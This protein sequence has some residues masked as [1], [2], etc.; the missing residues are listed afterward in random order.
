MNDLLFSRPDRFPRPDWTAIEERISQQG[1]DPGKAWESVA[2]QWMDAFANALGPDYKVHHSRDILLVT[3]APEP[4]VREILSFI[5]DCDKRILAELPFVDPSE[6]L[7]FLPIIV[8]GDEL[9]FYHYLGTLRDD[10]DDSA[11]AGGVFINEGYG[12]IAMPSENLDYYRATLCHELCHSFLSGFNLPLWLDEAI[13]AEVEHHITGENPYFLDRDI[14][15]EHRAY[16]NAG[17]LGAFW[18]GESFS[19]PDEGQGLSYHLARF[20]FHAIAPHSTPESISRFVRAAD[21]GNSGNSA[22]L[23]CFGIN[24]PDVVEG[25][26]GKTR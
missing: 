9:D 19:F 23:E 4:R 17:R 18:T 3:R 24:L 22:A 16:W 8:F 15:Q 2:V 5:H 10:D 25:L 7:G 6:F 13:T 1:D 21:D 12:H 14:I 20:L 11:T 26:L